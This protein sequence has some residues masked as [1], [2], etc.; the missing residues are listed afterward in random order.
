MRTKG[1]GTFYYDARGGR[2][3]GRIGPI[4]VTAKD[5]AKA[6]EKW[7]DAKD[8]YA[9]GGGKGKAPTIGELWDDLIRQKRIERRTER[10]IEWHEAIGRKHIA[11]IAARRA[12]TVNVA[13]LEAWLAERGNVEDEYRRKM[14]NALAQAF[15]IALR[16]RQITWNPARLVPL[17]SASDVEI[18]PEDDEVLTYLEVDQVLRAA[19]GDRLEAWLNLMVDTGMRPHESYG[20][21]W[22]DDVDLDGLNVTARPRKAKTKRPR[23]LEITA[24]TR[25]ALATHRASQ[26]RERLYMGDRWPAKYDQLVFR[27]E[28]GTPLD[29]HNMN[30]KLRSWLRAAGIDKDLTVYD[31]RKTVATLAADSGVM[32]VTL[33]DFLGSDPRTVERYYRKPVAPVRSLGFDLAARASQEK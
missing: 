28:V 19:V 8:R 9:K 3:V 6:K 17:P 1:E 14:V 24:R 25:T 33:A 22:D 23:L 2:Y 18:R 15:D 26:A 7:N 20:L 11:P 4:T 29:G 21:R 12:D 31:L 32:L 30:R 13:E 27:S 16:R 10:T 5:E